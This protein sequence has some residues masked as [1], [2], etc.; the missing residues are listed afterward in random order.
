MSRDLSAHAAW[1][2]PHL[3]VI[4]PDGAGPFPVV[5]QMHGCAG[6]GRIQTLYAEAAREAGV[7]A[8][9]IDSLAP[10][11]LGRI[12]A[13]LTVCT[14]L[15]LRGAERATD[16]LAVLAWLERQPWADTG[17]L[18]AAGW[19]HG[20]WSLMEALVAGSPQALALKLA[21]LFYPY[22]GLGAHTARSGWGDARPT[23]VAI[24][25]GRD[26]IVGRAAPTRALA[27]LRPTVCGSR[28]LN[29]PTPPTPLM[30]NSPMIPGSSIGRIC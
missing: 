5:A 30:M 16:L 10:R 25:A 7:A 12:E 24:L 18:A 29:S 15:R 21:V 11:G 13:G 1:L 14:G 6:C 4:R 22:A 23:V 28:P 3:T 20:G 17:R 8:V 9:I 26:R 19:S 27:R 2:A